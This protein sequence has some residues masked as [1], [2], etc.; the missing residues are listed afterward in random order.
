M[1][2]FEKQVEQGNVVH[3]VG[4]ITSSKVEVLIDRPDQEGVQ[5]DSCGITT[6]NVC[7]EYERDGV[8]SLERFLCGGCSHCRISEER[9]K[10]DEVSQCAKFGEF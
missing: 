3:A 8:K 5:V 1:S 9:R 10:E 6:G 2:T 7:V 4:R